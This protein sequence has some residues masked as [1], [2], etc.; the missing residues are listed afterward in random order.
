MNAPGAIELIAAEIADFNASVATAESR[1]PGNGRRTIG[2]LG[3]MDDYILRI[4]N[5]ESLLSYF[6][7]TSESEAAILASQLC[8]RSAIFREDSAAPEG[9]NPVFAEIDRIAAA[10]AT[11]HGG[12]AKPPQRNDSSLISVLARELSQAWQAVTEADMRLRT[13]AKGTTDHDAAEKAHSEATSFVGALE[14]GIAA[15]RV[16]SA[17]DAEIVTILLYAETQSMDEAR[18]RLLSLGLAAYTA[19]TNSDVAGALRERYGPHCSQTPA[20]G[21]AP[22][23]IVH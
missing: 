11:W 22:A 13:V 17:L 16:T 10:L 18:A 3:T 15:A 19:A 4:R 20:E 8:E 9:L 6:R 23:A 12:V 5:L 2:P 1:R 7:P 21:P 14:H